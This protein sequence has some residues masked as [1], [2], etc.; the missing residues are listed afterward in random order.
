MV[1]GYFYGIGVCLGLSQGN[2][3]MPMFTARA[4]VYGYVVGLLRRGVV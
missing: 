3:A 1:Y 4:Q 2:R